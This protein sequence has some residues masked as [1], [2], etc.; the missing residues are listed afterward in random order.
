MTAALTAFCTNA[1]V[2]SCVLLLPAAGVGAVGEPVRFGE[3]SGA[4]L[5]SSA[6]TALFWTG[7]ALVD[8]MAESMVGYGGTCHVPSL[9]R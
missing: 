5:P 3:A 2:A 8:E 1:V 6:L 7:L 9:R 4:F